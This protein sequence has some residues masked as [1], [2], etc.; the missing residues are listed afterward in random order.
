MAKAKGLRIQIQVGIEDGHKGSVQVRQSL[1]AFNA[2]VKANGWDSKLIP[3][4]A[5]AS[6]QR[7]RRFRTT[8]RRTSR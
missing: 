3:E 4:D 2:L 6:S 7:K 1:W 8:W 5:I